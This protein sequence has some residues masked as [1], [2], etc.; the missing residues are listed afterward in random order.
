HLGRVVVPVD[1]RAELHFLDDDVRGLALRFLAALVLLVL[2]LA[3]VHD[4]G[5]GRIGLGGDLNEVEPLLPGDLQRFGQ[6]LHAVLRTVGA[7]QSDLTSADAIVDAG[8]VCGDCGITSRS[9][10]AD[11]K[12]T[13]DTRKST[14]AP[15][16]RPEV[17]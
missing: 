5:H 2:V 13:A 16:D 9:R 11:A 12:T 14:V 1:L 4:L 15:D 8:L 3:V 10:A 7:D 17:W 6:R